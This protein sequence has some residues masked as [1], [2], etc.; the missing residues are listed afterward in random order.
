VRACVLDLPRVLPSLYSAS[1]DGHRPA[2]PLHAPSSRGYYSSPQESER[3]P[4]SCSPG[5]RTHARTH[6]RTHPLSNRRRAA[7]FPLALPRP[8]KAS[9][10]SSCTLFPVLWRDLYLARTHAAPPGQLQQDGDRTRRPNTHFSPR[11]PA[12]ALRLCLP[13]WGREK[14]AQTTPPPS[15]FLS[16][17]RGL[18]TVLPTSSVS[19]SIL[20]LSSCI[21]IIISSSISSSSEA[22]RVLQSHASA[23]F[24]PPPPDCFQDA[25]K[26]TPL[27]PAVGPARVLQCPPSASCYQSYTTSLLC[28]AVSL[29]LLSPPRKNIQKIFEPSR[30]CVVQNFRPSLFLGSHSAALHNSCFERRVR[31]LSLSLSYMRQRA[32][33]LIPRVRINRRAGNNQTSPPLPSLHAPRSAEMARGKVRTAL[34]TLHL[35]RPTWSVRPMRAHRRGKGQSR[36]GAVERKSERRERVFNRAL[37]N[38]LAHSA[39]KITTPGARQ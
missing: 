38:P 32:P 6:A 23:P 15:F 18:C 36:K 27:P 22:P 35:G 26:T 39:L 21:T 34:I 4:S 7:P 1:G 5:T 11:R 8:N 17:P 25:R 2:P 19:S 30:A 28:F 13:A 33:L 9:T 24:S 10:T 16:A 31:T 20:V 14:D 3:A 29:P 37:T 12:G